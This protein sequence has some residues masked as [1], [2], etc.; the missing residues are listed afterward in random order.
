VKWNGT[1]TLASSRYVFDYLDSQ[2]MVVL[3]IDNTGAGA[4]S[5]NTTLDLRVLEVDENGLPVPSR[6]KTN[7][8]YT[9]PTYC[10]NSDVVER[11]GRVSSGNIYYWCENPKRQAVYTINETTYS[12]PL[13]LGSRREEGVLNRFIPAPTTDGKVPTWGL[14]SD[15][16]GLLFALHLSGPDAGNYYNSGKKLSAK[17]N[18]NAVEITIIS[19]DREQ[20]EEKS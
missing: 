10:T 3:K 16:K 5:D 19:E 14:V 2:R 7:V 1:E 4:T 11:H 8:S 18:L 15:S 13:H 6:M 12:Q 9:L 17:Y 20:E